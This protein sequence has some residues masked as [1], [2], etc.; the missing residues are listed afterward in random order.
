MSYGVRTGSVQ[1]REPDRSGRESRRD[2]SMGRTV[3]RA[4]A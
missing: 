4:R 2:D 3:A 1:E